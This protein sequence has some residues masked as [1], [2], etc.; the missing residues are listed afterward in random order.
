MLKFSSNLKK[1]VSGPFSVLFTDSPISLTLSLADKKVWVMGSRLYEDKTKCRAMY[2]HRARTQGLRRAGVS[3][4]PDYDKD[5]VKSWCST[6]NSQD[7]Q[8]LIPNALTISGRSV[9]VSRTKSWDLQADSEKEY[10]VVQHSRFY[11]VAT[12]PSSRVNAA[13]TSTTRNKTVKQVKGGNCRGPVVCSETGSGLFS[14]QAIRDISS[15]SPKCRNVDQVRVSKNK[16]ITCVFTH[17]SV[18]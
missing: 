8:S 15:R 5:S 10:Q 11:R 14:T 18:I 3:V 4:T 17:I 7:S 1:Y 13:G 6:R 16:K 9:P 12:T 2:N